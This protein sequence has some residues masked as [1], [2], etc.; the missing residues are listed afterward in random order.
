MKI[1]FLKPKQETIET[2]SENKTEFKTFFLSSGTASWSNSNYASFASEGYIKN[3][4]A[5]RCITLLS[6]A[7]SFI[8]LRLFRIENGKKNEVKTHPI[9]DLLNRPSKFSSKMDF[10]ESIYSYKLI[11][12]NVYIRAILF[13]GKPVE[14]QVIRPDKVSVLTGK[15]EEVCGYRV[16]YASGDKDFYFNQMNEKCEI[17]HLKSFHPLN[18]Y[19]GLSAV[20]C[21]RYAIDQHNEAS[22]YAKALLQNSARPSGAL[23][24]KATEYNSG[25]TLTEPQFVRLKEQL[26][27]QFSG[28]GNTGKPMLLE[29]GLD[30]KEMSISPRDMDF[31]ENKNSASREIALAFGVPPQLLGLPGD[32][33]YNN[34]MEARIAMWEQTIIPM[35]S[36]AILGFSNWL[37]KLFGEEIV[38]EFNKESISAL[39]H[40]RET[41]WEKIIKAD[42]LTEDEKR[43]YFGFPPKLKAGKVE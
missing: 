36:D 11:A 19:Y 43:E 7:A 14:L 34:M 18:E 2:K 35:M 27:D 40:K 1:P 25:G 33:T 24:V 28:I 8:P 37:S 5:H 6:S 20:E 30:W 13:K 23:I 15:N 39:T 22:T 31:M 9:L 42:F 26:Y 21:A 10:F 12:G 17:L 29:G 38:I 32:S 4:I 16:S 3:V 41:E